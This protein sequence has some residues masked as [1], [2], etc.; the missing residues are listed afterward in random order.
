MKSQRLASA[1]NSQLGS[2]SRIQGAPYNQINI[3]QNFLEQ[4]NIRPKSAIL[5]NK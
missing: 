5:N 2:K 4:D 1:R 3:L